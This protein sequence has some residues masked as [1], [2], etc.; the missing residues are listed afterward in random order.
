MANTKFHFVSFSR[1]SETFCGVLYIFDLLPMMSSACCP[2]WLNDAESS[3]S[4]DLHE[5]A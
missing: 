5:N 4:K 1:E 2:V 3:L